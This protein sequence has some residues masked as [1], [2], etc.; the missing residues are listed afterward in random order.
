MLLARVHD[1]ASI[2]VRESAYTRTTHAPM[3]PLVCSG[4]AFEII[5]IDD[6][7]PDGTQDIVRRLQKAYDGVSIVSFCRLA[8]M[9]MSRMP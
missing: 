9:L 7:S 4:E 3:H 2:I 8:P 1:A 6:N 5:V